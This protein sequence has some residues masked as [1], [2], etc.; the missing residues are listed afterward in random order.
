MTRWFGIG[1]I[2]RPLKEFS[3]H[4]WGCIELEAPAA[5]EQK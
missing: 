4:A 1:N 3:A 2:A 5:A